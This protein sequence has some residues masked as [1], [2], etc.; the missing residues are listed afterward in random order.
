MTYWGNNRL[1][2]EFL[3][4]ENKLNPVWI[5][6]YH[7]DLNEFDRDRHERFVSKENDEE[8]I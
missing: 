1:N 5:K 7:S 6:E 4:I 8:V 3:E 2:E